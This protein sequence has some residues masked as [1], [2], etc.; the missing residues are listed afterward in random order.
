MSPAANARPAARPS[1]GARAI[2]TGAPVSAREAATS[3]PSQIATAYGEGLLSAWVVCTSESASMTSPTTPATTAA[4]WRPGRRRG[5]PCALKTASAAIPAAPTP[6]TSDNG[7]SR[8]AAR[9]RS[10]PAD[11]TPKLTSQAV[12]CSRR[13]TAST[14]RRTDSSGI[15][16]TASCCVEYD[17]LIATAERNE[18]TRPPANATARGYAVRSDLVVDPAV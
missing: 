17:Q 13:R 8:S 4:C 2:R 11:S 10:Q 6:C 14:G 16:A 5:W 1:A 15:V 7:A 18:R 12:L 9:Y 3:A